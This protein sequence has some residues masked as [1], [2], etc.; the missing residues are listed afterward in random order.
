MDIVGSIERYKFVTSNLSIFVD[1]LHNA[2]RS[3]RLNV[4][5]YLYHRKKNIYI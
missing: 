5:I 4:S 2:P 1:D 3:L